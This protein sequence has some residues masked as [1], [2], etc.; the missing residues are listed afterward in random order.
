MR[1]NALR[2]RGVGLTLIELLATLSVAAVIAA[3]GAP[4]L[5]DV[6]LEQRMVARVNGFVH[7]I[8]LAKQAAHAR[9]TEA[10]ICKSRDGEQCDA[11]ADWHDGWVLF[12]NLDRDYPATAD[13]AE[14][15]LAS[16]PAFR[17]GSIRANRQA[18]VFR[19]FEIRSTNGTLVFC[20]RRGPAHARAVIVSYTGR[21]RI[22]TTR[23]DG[24]AL[25]CPA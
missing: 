6:L 4:A 8:Y 14:P 10:V 23:P 1:R 11:G 5:R 20:D 16:G 2:W 13:P 21:P 3:I 7:G 17:S 24:D 22:A 12:A 18:F 19:P 25:Q 9:L 15:L